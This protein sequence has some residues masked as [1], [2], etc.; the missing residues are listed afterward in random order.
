MARVFC[1]AAIFLTFLSTSF[2]TVREISSY[3]NSQSDNDRI[4]EDDTAE[5]MKRETDQIT[6]YGL[7]ILWVEPSQTPYTLFRQFLNGFSGARFM[8]FKKNITDTYNVSRIAK[9][10]ISDADV[11]CVKLVP[12]TEL[13]ATEANENPTSLPERPV[14]DKLNHVAEAL[15][16]FMNSFHGPD[17]YK[18]EE[19]RIPILRVA[20]LITDT[21]PERP[22]KNSLKRGKHRNVGCKH[23]GPTSEQVKTTFQL[24][25]AD[26][27]LISIKSNLKPSWDDALRSTERFAFK[28][29]TVPQILDNDFQEADNNIVAFVK[30]AAEMMARRRFPA[31]F[32]DEAVKVDIDAW[33]Q[34]TVPTK[35]LQIEGPPMGRSVEM[36]SSRPKDAGKPYKEA[37]WIRLVLAFGKIFGQ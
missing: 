14:L 1:V 21:L 4:L 8:T 24:Y 34:P 9:A 36:I 13:E 30:E 2:A 32:E 33:L 18:S 22:S 7:D 35:S 25:G 37:A 29:L 31:L 26:M 6:K 11:D 16:N 15:P 12:N 19:E 17:F 20:V 28:S 5:N 10:R 27:L 3:L 23:V